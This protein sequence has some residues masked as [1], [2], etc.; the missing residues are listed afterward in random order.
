MS[1]AV[2]NGQFDAQTMVVDEDLLMSGARFERAV[3][4]SGARVAGALDAVAA[5]LNGLNL[6]GATV[7]QDLVFAH[8]PTRTAP[9][10]TPS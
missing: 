8:L 10:A 1:D 5:S 6:S 3:E 4:L 2:F 7:G 9:S